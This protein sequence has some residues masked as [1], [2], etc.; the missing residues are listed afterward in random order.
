[1]LH[2]ALGLQQIKHRV[3]AV[4]AVIG[5]DQKIGKA[6]RPMIGESFQNIGPLIFHR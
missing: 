6:D 2:K 5:V 1:M 4:T 3:G